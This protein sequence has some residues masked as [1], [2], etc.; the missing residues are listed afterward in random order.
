M[1]QSQYEQEVRSPTVKYLSAVGD[2]G[3]ELHYTLFGD[4]VGATEDDRRA[5][6]R[7]LFEIIEEYACQ[8]PGGQLGAEARFTMFELLKSSTKLAGG[9]ATAAPLNLK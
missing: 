6:E 4:R 9:A 1:A 3:I 8:Q 2:A 7:R 5:F